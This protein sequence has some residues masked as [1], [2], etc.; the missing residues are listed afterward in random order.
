[1]LSLKVQRTLMSIL[2][3][4]GAIDDTGGS[5]LEF[6][7][8]NGI[9]VRFFGS[10]ESLLRIWVFYV[11]FK[12]AKNPHVLIA[13]NWGCGWNLRFLI[14]VLDI[15]LDFSK[16]VWILGIF[17][18]NFEFLCWVYRWKEPSYPYFLEFGLW[19]MLEAPDWSFGSWLGYK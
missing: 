17:V 8:L 11:E 4:I 6:W 16:L 15:D 1:M 9:L 3:W 19:M 10:W 5:W 14:E 12:G 2:P 7:I 13:L 18:P